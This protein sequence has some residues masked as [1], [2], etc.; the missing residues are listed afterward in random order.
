LFLK[1]AEQ[2]DV[3]AAYNVGLIYAK[4]IGVP[5][6]EVKGYMWLLIAA[7]FG[8]VPSQKALKDLDSGIAPLKVAGA[9]SRA[10]AWVKDHPDVKPILF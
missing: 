9:R 8:Y 1:S 5:K 4:A 2:G 7:H 10:D 6:D 3:P